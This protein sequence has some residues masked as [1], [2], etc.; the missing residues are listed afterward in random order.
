[1]ILS[2]EV[3]EKMAEAVH[4]VWMEEKFADG[5]TLGDSTDKERKIHSC[6]VPYD[7]LSEKDKNSDRD[8]ARGIPHILEIAGYKIVPKG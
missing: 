6:L 1:M 8:I 4:Q 7:E 3:I 2:E 5:W